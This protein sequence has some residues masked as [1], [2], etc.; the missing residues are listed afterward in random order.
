FLPPS[1]PSPMISFGAH[2]PFNKLVH[3]IRA[4]LIDAPV[5]DTG[6]WQ[7]IVNPEMP[8]SRTIEVED[9]SFT[10]NI[11]DSVEVLREH[12]KPNLPWADLHFA[13]R[14]SGVPYN[15]PPSHVHWP[16][17]VNANDAHRSDEKFSHTYP[18]RMWPK[19]VWPEF[20]G[21]DTHMER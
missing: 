7:A 3:R 18:E 5:V 4:L 17:A 2:I 11:P 1:R 15:P 9:V 8:Q 19:F 21:Q 16:F 12:V 6:E 13:E 14:V 20:K 10:F